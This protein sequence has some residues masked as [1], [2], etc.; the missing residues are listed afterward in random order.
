MTPGQVVGMIN[1]TAGFL[2]LLATLIG[3]P[4]GLVFTKS[5]LTL[6][7]QTY[8]LSQ[9]ALTLNIFYVLLLIPLMVGISMLGSFIPSRQAAR[10]PIVKV[11]RNE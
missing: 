4:L 2:G 6:L 7:S 5:I 8:G 9:V 1:T 10:L 11:L 3:V